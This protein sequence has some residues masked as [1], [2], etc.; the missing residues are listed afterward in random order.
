MARPLEPEATV[1]LL[2]RIKDGDDAA[3]NRLLRRCVPAL[4]CWAHGRLPPSARGMLETADLV[5]DAVL[6]GLRRL[7]TFEARHQGALQA[8]FRAS[9]MNR[10]RDVIREERRR[11][12]QTEFPEGLASEEMSPLELAI[13]LEN[14]EHYEVALERLNPAERQAIICRLELQYSYQELAVVLNKPS[15]AA[16]RMA[17]TRAMKRL[18][19]E[20]R[21]ASR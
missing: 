18:V 15:P 7:D 11:P 17:V 8:Y 2:A 10:I 13:G 1:E 4:Q 21:D 6:A 14:L 3:L 5:Q 16:A 20:L 19:N 12:R 9:V